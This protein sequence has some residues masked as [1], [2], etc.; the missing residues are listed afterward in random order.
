MEKDTTFQPFFC[1]KK[2]IEQQANQK[3]STLSKEIL[4]TTIKKFLFS[5]TNSTSY[6]L[7]FK[8][9]IEEDFIKDFFNDN[10]SVIE[11]NKIYDGMYMPLYLVLYSTYRQYQYKH[12][13]KSE[14]V[15]KMKSE[16]SKKF[17]NRVKMNKMQKSELLKQFSE[18]YPEIEKDI[19]IKVL[20]TTAG[21]ISE[22]ISI[23]I[24]I[25]IGH[26]P[27]RKI[28][29]YLKFFQFGTLNTTPKIS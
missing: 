17:I 21:K 12:L 6:S 11:E 9:L 25:L 15:K 26:I 16:G 18:K 2:Y 23:N 4:D 10:L 24:H 28:N 20:S 8:G 5:I 14:M 3:K 22:Q 1:L 13:M 27:Y 7:E 29:K 19:L